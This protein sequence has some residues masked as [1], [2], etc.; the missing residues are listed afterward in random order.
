MAGRHLRSYT[1]NQDLAE[2]DEPDDEGGA[3]RGDG[4]AQRRFSH[5]AGEA[6]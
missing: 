2:R 3:L 4:S 5:Q 1:C 6:L